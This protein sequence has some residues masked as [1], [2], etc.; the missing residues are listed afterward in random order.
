ML[1]A[2]VAWMAL[3]VG[4]GVA[5]GGA[6]DLADVEQPAIR[7]GEA[8]ASGSGA[9]AEADVRRQARSGTTR[10]RPELDPE[11][12][13]N[14]PGIRG[15]LVDPSGRPLGGLRVIAEGRETQLQYLP[16]PSP[17]PW[18]RGTGTSGKDGRFEIHR[19]WSLEGLRVRAG[20]GS[21]WV[22]DSALGDRITYKVRVPGEL[23]DLGDLELHPTAGLRGRVVAADG[24]PVVGAR[25]VLRYFRKFEKG[26]SA[27]QRA[28]TEKSYSESCEKAP[29]SQPSEGSLQ[30][31]TGR[32]EGE[33]RLQHEYGHDR[34]QPAVSTDARG[35]FAVPGLRAGF[36]WVSAVPV[37]RM[38]C[39]T[40]TS[41]AAGQAREV[42]LRLPV[43]RTVRGTVR[44]VGGQPIAGATVQL[45]VIEDDDRV[46]CWPKLPPTDAAGKFTVDG[47]VGDKLAMVVQH[48]VTGRRAVFG[49]F[50]VG[51]EIVVTLPELCTLEV[52]VKTAAG[53]AVDDAALQVVTDEPWTFGFGDQSHMVLPA[54]PVGGVLQLSPGRYWVI[55]DCGDRGMAWERAVVTQPRQRVE[56]TLGSP[57]PLTVE[58]VDSADAPVFGARVSL[59]VFRDPTWY[60]RRQIAFTDREGRAVLPILGPGGRS[61]GVHAI[62]FARGAVEL[63]SDDTRAKVVLHRHSR[64]KMSVRDSLGAALDGVTWL[65]FVGPT[66][67][68]CRYPV[69]P[70]G[71]EE[72]VNPGEYRLL[73]VMLRSKYGAVDVPFDATG[74]HVVVPEG[75]SAELV[76]HVD[77]RD[78]RGNHRITGKVSVSGKPVAGL[79]VSLSSDNRRFNRQ[80]LIGKDGSFVL[81]GVTFREVFVVIHKTGGGNEIRLFSRKV[82]LDRPEV[83][84]DIDIAPGGMRGEVLGANGQRL[85]KTRCLVVEEDVAVAGW[86]VSRADGTVE[87]TSL[88]PGRY[89]LLNMRHRE[90]QSDVFTVRSGE[91]TTGVVLRCPAIVAVSGQVTL[92]GAPPAGAGWLVGFTSDRESHQFEVAPDGRFSTSELDA[93][94]R[95]RVWLMPTGAMRRHDYGREVQ[96]PAGGLSDLRLEFSR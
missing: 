16:G 37:G 66:G 15:R 60:E 71:K 84:L 73:S 40:M 8:G 43:G 63:R 79:T 49:P 11:F 17:L 24:S 28:A 30:L 12:L 64:L 82:T 35:S 31:G 57:K 86:V 93:G 42:E 88:A 59:C 46:A 55:A 32:E 5:R 81:E 80:F 2:A 70:A 23:V 74:T 92:D 85:G 58:V 94:M 91:V 26:A 39:T 36:W 54:A 14:L 20:E 68:Y 75:G 41:L 21:A 69:P 22:F 56:L 89:R 7:T 65:H 4:F 44:G 52:V 90:V 47:F 1:L 38:A 87:A 10:S 29:H 72:S 6:A 34:S 19:V 51:A 95:Y 25:V 3:G 62:G 61:L 18:L 96:V 13:A 77:S 67:R 27:E 83:H 33:V 50:D 48:P 53:A 76:A 45:L 78:V 9:P